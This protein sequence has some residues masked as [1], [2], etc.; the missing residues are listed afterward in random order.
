MG[1]DLFNLYT[2]TSLTWL[3]EKFLGLCNM[4]LVIT[5][6]VYGSLHRSFQRLINHALVG[7]DSAYAYLCSDMTSCLRVVSLNSRFGWTGNLIH[8]YRYGGL[9][10]CMVSGV[11]DKVSFCRII[12][13][14]PVPWYMAFIFRVA[15]F[16]WFCKISDLKRSADSV[17][18]F[19]ELHVVRQCGCFPLTPREMHWF[20]Q[21][22]IVSRPLMFTEDINMAIK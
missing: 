11:K 6:Q 12:E 15:W 9:S 7:W 19:Y 22:K 8:W 1:F 14:F 17:W 16:N 2:A 5:Y 20:C 18:L 4:D 21:L 3:H 10:F 13:I